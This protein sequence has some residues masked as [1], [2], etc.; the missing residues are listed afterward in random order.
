M[1]LNP[2]ISGQLARQVLAG[3]S[4]LPFLVMLPVFFINLAYPDMI[5]AGN[6][7]MFL[8]ELAKSQR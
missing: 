1:R 7:T 3:D 2:V 6:K 4:F 8:I 5:A